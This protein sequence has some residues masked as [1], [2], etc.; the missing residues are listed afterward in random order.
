[1]GQ[2]FYQAAEFFDANRADLAERLLRLDLEADPR[3][4]P[5]MALLAMCLR[6]RGRRTEAVRI[7]QEAVE[8]APDR[9]FTHYAMGCVHLGQGRRGLR[10]ARRALDQALALEPFNPEHLFLLASIRLDQG[11]TREALELTARGLQIDPQHPRCLSLRA[12]ALTIQGRGGEAVETAS[13]ALAS[14]PAGAYTHRLAAQAR[15]WVGDLT[16]GERHLAEALRLDPTAQGLEHQLR[17]VR[18]VLRLLQPQL[19][20]ARRLRL[21]RPP[22]ALGRSAR[23][24]WLLGA[25]A[26]AGLAQALSWATGE[27]GLRTAYLVLFGFAM[28]WALVARVSE[29]RGGKVVAVLV[30]TLVWVPLAA[31]FS[32]GCT[33]LLVGS[34]GTRTGLLGSA[35][36]PPLTVAGWLFFLVVVCPR[37]G[38]QVV[39]VVPLQ[40]ATAAAA[41]TRP[42]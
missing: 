3:D 41:G 29:N 17:S 37:I 8:L 2:H 32:A 31:A 35:L 9:G 18:R 26:L 39:G 27:A 7:A 30:M 12:L 33:G 10:R 28:V 1:M 38:D 36:C 42:G 40:G 16:A 19:R 22:R 15:L 24:N 5:S 11:A 25:G 23:P 20:L 4:A 21:L 13:R 34:G 14:D 6:R